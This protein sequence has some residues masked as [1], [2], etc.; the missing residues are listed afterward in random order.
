MKTLRQEQR[1]LMGISDLI[2]IVSVWLQKRLKK[3]NIYTK[4]LFTNVIMF[5]VVMV[6]LTFISGFVVKQAH[7]NQL[8]Q[9][10]LLKARRVNFALHQQVAWRATSETTS[11]RFPEQELL[12]FLADALD[13]KVTIF[14]LEGS[15]TGASAEQDVLTGNKVETRALEILISGE[16]AI[17]RRHDRATGQLTFVAVIAMGNNNDPIE[18]GILLEAKP[19]QVNIALN[20]MRLYL[21]FGGLVGLLMVI[22]ISL[23]LAMNIS[24]PISRLTTA[25]TELESA[26]GMVDTATESLDEINALTTQLAKAM[27]KLQKVQVESSKL[28]E[29][30]VRMFA[31]IS[32]EL[33]TP[34]TSIQGLVE[35]VRDGMVQDEAVLKRYLD[36]IFTQTVH[37]ARLVDD[38]LALSRLESGDIT[39]EKLPVDLV[40]LAQRV[41]MS[42]EG[43]ATSK[44]TS[45][46]L[47][48]QA[49]TAFV[50]GDVDRMEQIIR[51]ILK[52]AIQ[53]T[54]NGTIRVDVG[55]QQD[56]VVL[57]IAD[58]GVG[59]PSEDLPHIW[60]RFYR[61]KNQCAT[62]LGDKGSGLGL[63]IVKKLVQLQSG[64]ICVES[65]L[66]KG[67]TVRL[68]FPT[69]DT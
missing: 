52:N 43:M 17:Y 7:Y 42:L 67:T 31:D 53:A 5:A 56:E 38:L 50:V 27:V 18:N 28:E 68:N 3:K 11:G 20:Q 48:A 1:R 39:V 66:G 44:N 34:L 36:I 46:V 24:D 51:N 33:R 16:P 54:K 21:L 37:L 30:R 32:H 65:Q 60:D 29:N 47:H 22:F 59:I 13:V 69:F 15:I 8:Q 9:E 62:V 45:I 6:V 19:L 64:R 49:V 41:A 61:V 14:S 25:V 58:N 10:L 26:S 40:A 55:V 63:V 2:C 35:A 57:T 12:K 23:H 4:I